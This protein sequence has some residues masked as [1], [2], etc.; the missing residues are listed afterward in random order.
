MPPWRAQRC[1][2]AGGRVAAGVALQRGRSRSS[3]QGRLQQWRR[4]CGILGV[5]ARRRAPRAMICLG[6]AIDDTRG[7]TSLARSQAACFERPASEDP[8]RGGVASAVAP[9][10]GTQLE[11]RWATAGECQMQYHRQRPCG[12][13]F[14]AP[15]GLAVFSRWGPGS[16]SCGA[17]IDPGRML[18]LASGGTT[19]RRAGSAP[20]RPRRARARQDA[21]RACQ[22]IAA[23]S[24]S[25]VSWQ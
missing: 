13:L 8:M 24:V 22:R 14:R 1:G 21:C 19:E 12:C 11:G 25:F 5:D 10:A 4:P 6:R 3:E 18:G 2:A 15:A 23:R 20:R 7:A 17:Q 9:P 16:R